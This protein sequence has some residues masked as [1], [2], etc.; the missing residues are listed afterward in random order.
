MSE[1]SYEKV[2]S[3]FNQR[4]WY[5]AFSHTLVNIN[6]FYLFRRITSSYFSRGNTALVCLS[7][8]FPNIKNT[9]VLFVLFWLSLWEKSTQNAHIIARFWHFFACHYS[10]TVWLAGNLSEIKITHYEKI[11]SHIEQ[12]FSN[13]KRELGIKN[14]FLS[15][16]DYHYFHRDISH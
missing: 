14:I 3:N 9:W 10:K 4:R 16:W 6:S 15:H 2:T 13:F 11:F 8:V 1:S 5:L 7:K 12:K